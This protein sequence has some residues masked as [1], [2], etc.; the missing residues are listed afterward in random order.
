MTTFEFDLE[1]RDGG[2]DI[3]MHARGV[4]WVTHDGVIE[5]VGL[6]VWDKRNRT[7]GPA[8]RPY[9]KGGIFDLVA[10]N[11]YE[12][13]PDAIERAAGEHE[14]ATTFWRQADSLMLPMHR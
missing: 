13:M 7:Y 12:Q 6:Y 9:T 5:E 2:Q 14:P 1:L 8:T 11:L 4:A 3:D 10:R